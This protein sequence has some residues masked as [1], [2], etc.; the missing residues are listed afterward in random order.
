MPSPLS[1]N[2]RPKGERENENDRGGDFSHFA[3]SK[4]VLRRRRPLQQRALA[5]R[6]PNPAERRKQIKQSPIIRDSSFQSPGRTIRKRFQKSKFKRFWFHSWLRQE[7]E[8]IIFLDARRAFNVIV[9]YHT[10]RSMLP[11][12]SL[13]IDNAC[14]ARV[15]ER[16]GEE[17]AR[18][19]SFCSF[20]S[21]D[22]RLNQL[23][24]EPWPVEARL[25][26]FATKE[27]SNPSQV[28]FLTSQRHRLPS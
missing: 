19:S 24:S 22:T 13:I 20:L 21:P 8:H 17:G 18:S 5:P 7:W 15:R 1:L 3:Q 12:L 25:A 28:C 10:P 4:A 23:Q 6:P 9:I 14:A 2:R 11:A 27:F 26:N 16:A